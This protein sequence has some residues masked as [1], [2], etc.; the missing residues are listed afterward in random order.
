MTAAIAVVL[1]R[2]IVLAADHLIGPTEKFHQA[3][4]AA[5]GFLQEHPEALISGKNEE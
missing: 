3:V 5:D 2:M 4:Q 1:V